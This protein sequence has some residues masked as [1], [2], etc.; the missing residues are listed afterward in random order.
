MC[1]LFSQNTSHQQTTLLIMETKEIKETKETN[2]TTPQQ[3]S[4]H[5]MPLRIYT[6]RRL[7]MVLPCPNCFIAQAIEG[8]EGQFCAGC[9]NNYTISREWCEM[10]RRQN[11]DQEQNQEQKEA[12]EGRC[13]CQEWLLEEKCLYT[14]PLEQYGED[15]TANEVRALWARVN[16]DNI[17]RGDRVVSLSTCHSDTEEPC[18]NCYGHYFPCSSSCNP[19]HYG[20]LSYSQYR[21]QNVASSRLPTVYDVYML[22]TRLQLERISQEAWDELEN[23]EGKDN[24]DGDDL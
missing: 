18:L 7:R 10:S 15:Y 4:F 2:E 1:L 21:E 20:V 24:G 3:Q 12:S 8:K 5:L 9:I 23:P 17:Q 11:Q 6:N 22:M 19:L 13:N 16:W 14:K